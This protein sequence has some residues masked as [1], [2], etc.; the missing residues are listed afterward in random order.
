VI[1]AIQ[2]GRG[3]PPD[4]LIC[5]EGGAAWIKL[6]DYPPFA[7]A[8]PAVVQQ[9]PRSAVYAP[10]QAVGA[11]PVR[12]KSASEAKWLFGIG[13]LIGL[14][15]PKGGGLLGLVM[16]LGLIAWTVARHR[17]GKKSLM[18]TA[19]SKPIGIWTT[20]GTLAIGGLFTMFGTSSVL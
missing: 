17:K 19:W 3:G 6:R 5:A 16:G 4:T 2:G 13:T 9:P 15:V 12:Q 20:A 11:K 8:L 18:A 10:G 1:A 7:A 14:G